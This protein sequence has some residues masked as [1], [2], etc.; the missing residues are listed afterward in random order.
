M[1]HLNTMKAKTSKGK[2]LMTKQ[3]LKEYMNWVN[4]FANQKTVTNKQSKTKGK[5][6][7]TNKKQ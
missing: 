7:E 1:K 2:C 6:N 5:K 3:E 4:S